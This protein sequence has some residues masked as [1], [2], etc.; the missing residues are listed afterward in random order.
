VKAV[1]TDTVEQ[2]CC[3]CSL[4]MEPQWITA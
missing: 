3:W 4:F 1:N 2:F